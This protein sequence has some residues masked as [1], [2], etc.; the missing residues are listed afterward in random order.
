MKSKAIAHQFEF[1]EYLGEAGNFFRRD[2]GYSTISAEDFTWPSRIFDLSSPNVGLLKQTIQLKG[3]PHSIAVEDGDTIGKEL[4]S[5][6]FQIRSVVAGMTLL[7]KTSMSFSISKSIHR[8]S[9]QEQIKIFANIASEAFGY[10]IY[11][12]SLFGLLGA[13]RVQL[14]MGR[15]KEDYVSCGILFLDSNKDSGLHMIGLKKDFRGLGLGKAM[16]SHLLH[17]AIKNKSEQVHLLASK[18]GSPIYSKLGFQ[19]RGYLKSYII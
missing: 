1:W 16:T 18:L 19:N 14:F 9:N 4:E 17:H 15:Y 2:G 7:L 6:G 10:T 8:V 3:M 13:N 11:P 5:I 12:S